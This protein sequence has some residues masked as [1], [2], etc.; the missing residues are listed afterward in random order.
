VREITVA[1]RSRD[2][3]KSTLAINLHYRLAQGE[4]PGRTN[5]MSRFLSV[6]ALT[7]ASLAP[8]AMPAEAYVVRHHR[9]AHNRERHPVR[10]SVKRIGIGAAGGAATG[11]LI[12]GGPGAAIGAVAGGTAG[13]VY[14][15]HEKRIGK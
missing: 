3:R 5:K 14:D 9:Y 12:G 6:A 7:I 10:K 11:A 13:A 2:E 4:S 15:H 8:A 1:G